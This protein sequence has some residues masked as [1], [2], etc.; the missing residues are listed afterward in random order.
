MGG[1]KGSPERVGGREEVRSDYG[2][3]TPK[4]T[5]RDKEGLTPDS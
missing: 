4:E 3:L 1:R 2:T 5:G